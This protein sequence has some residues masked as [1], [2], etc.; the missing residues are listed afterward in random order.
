MRLGSRIVRPGCHWSDSLDAGDSGRDVANRDDAPRNSLKIPRRR[1][2]CFGVICF[3]FH[4]LNLAFARLALSNNR[5]TT[6]RSNERRWR[7]I[8]PATT[9]ACLDQPAAESNRTRRDRSECHTG[10]SIQERRVDWPC[11]CVMTAVNWLIDFHKP[12]TSFWGAFQ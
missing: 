3:W 12:W 10:R 6:T 11:R 1:W 9:M 2:I 8:Q 4:I 7:S 5:K